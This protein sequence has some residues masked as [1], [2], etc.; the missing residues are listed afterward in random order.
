MTAVIEQNSPAVGPRKTGESSSRKPARLAYVLQVFP[1]LTMTFVYREVLALQ[2]R[3][4]EIDAFS[5][6]RPTVADLS[7]EAR[8]F[9]DRTY[10]VFP[11]PWLKFLQS[12]LH[13]LVTR[14]SNYVGTALFVLTRK[15]ETW[16]H[17]LR[18]AYHFAEATYLAR[19][20]ERRG[21]R[22]I[23][24]H[25]EINAA[26]IAL[27]V[28]R[29]LGISFSFTTHNNLFTDRILLK[30]KLREALFVAVISEFSR[31]FLLDMAPGEDWRAK[32]HIVRC[33]LS[34][35]QFFPS[36]VRPVNAIPLILFV[37][38]LAERKGAPI[39]VEACKILRDRGLAFRCAIAGDG[40]DKA[41]VD[42]LVAQYGLKEHV[43]LTGA[44]LQEQLKGYLDQ[45]DI[46]ALP[47]IR[48]ANG[49][50]DGIPVVL[51]EAMACNIATVSTPVSGIPE[52]IQ[53]G[54]TGLLVPE[55]DAVSL[56]NALQRLIEDRDL[57][58][59]LGE[60]GRNKVLSEFD[61]DQN[62]ARLAAL[63]DRYVPCDDP[64]RQAPHPTRGADR[65]P[66]RA[67]RARR[68]RS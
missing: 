65:C 40:P 46:F 37:A 54:E 12:H 28:A 5:V 47:C 33:G 52:L 19:E 61:S 49:D 21:I 18:T 22:H 16:R 14:P 1:D 9:V 27:I 31:A 29:L 42:R 64:L 45:A 48:A 23:H 43:T 6:W 53:D 15:A 50:M 26:S 20:I 8:H 2:K 66:G 4:L 55:K 38:Q 3:S 62:A 59:R 7:Y 32:T 10:Y 34:P 51:M 35:S 63:F 36:R 58:V 25:F 56:A 60:N 17:R 30:E 13:F 41:L 44:I 57:R 68:H 24:A 39:L 11:L 67:A